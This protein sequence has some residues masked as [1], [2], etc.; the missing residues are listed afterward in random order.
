VSSPLTQGR[1]VWVTVPD[2]RGGNPKQRPAVIVSA[3]DEIVPGGEV[4]VA[5]ITT[6]LGQSRFSETVE[7]PSL[8]AGHPDTKLKRPS[9]VV[10]S[11]VTRVAV[12]DLRDAGGFLPP[13]VLTEVLVK[14][15]RL[16]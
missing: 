11:W 14:V 1:I 6:Q 7:L 2:P 15:E 4:L 10:C 5:A 13:D 12:A 3:T 8:P 9:E 16:N